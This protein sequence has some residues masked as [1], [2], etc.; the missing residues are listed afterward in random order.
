MGHVVK[1]AEGALPEVDG[2]MQE[3]GSKRGGARKTKIARVT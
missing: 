3:G 1:E 2:E